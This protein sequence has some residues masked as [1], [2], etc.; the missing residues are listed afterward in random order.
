MPSTPVVLSEGMGV[1]SASIL[2]RWL[3]EPASRDFS[4]DDL[5]V[6]T[7]MTGDEHK[8]GTGEAFTRHLL[9]LMRQQR[10]RY[11]QV[12]RAGPSNEDGVVILDDSREP[13]RLHLEGAWRLSD[14]LLRAATVPQ[15]AHGRRLCSIKFKGW[16]L[17]SWL[18]EHLDG[19]PYRHVMGFNAQE[20]KRIQRDTSYS[21]LT[22]LSEYPLLAWGWTRADCEAYLMQHTGI[23]WPKSCCTFCP[24]AGG[25]SEALER[26]LAEPGAA[27][28]ALLVEHLALA[29]NPR[30]TLYSSGTLRELLEQRAPGVVADFLESLRLSPWAVYRV[31]RILWAKGRGARELTTLFHGS[32]PEAEAHLRC[33]APAAHPSLGSLRSWVRH[34]EPDTFPTAEEMLVACPAIPQDKRRPSFTASWARATSGQ[35]VQLELFAA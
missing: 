4:L 28:E 24:F 32:K 35:G 12:A 5:I 13:H 11:V 3:L 25:R 34:R 21:T 31:R 20:H 7:A 29:C 10:V 15:F 2:L 23:R 26:L 8:Q 22:R 1:E 9:P 6:L 30:S 17:D 14:E 19:R 18:A 16:V 33:L 27:R